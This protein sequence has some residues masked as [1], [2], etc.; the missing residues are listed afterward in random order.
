AE[1][2]VVRGEWIA[3]VEH[4]AGAQEEGPGQTVLGH[5][6]ALGIARSHSALLEIESDEAV[7]HDGLVDG[8]ARTSLQDRIEGLS[9]ER[10]NRQNQSAPLHLRPGWRGDSDSAHDG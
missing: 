10:F 6:P 1:L 8:V 2:N 4:L 7:I 3:I 9:G 5:D